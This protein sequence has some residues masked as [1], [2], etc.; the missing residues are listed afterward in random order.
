MVLRLEEFLHKN[1]AIKEINDFAGLDVFQGVTVRT[2]IL[3]TMR[4]NSASKRHYHKIPSTYRYRDI[5]PV[6]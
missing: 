1:A 2:V 6:S 3:L 4:T 5:Y